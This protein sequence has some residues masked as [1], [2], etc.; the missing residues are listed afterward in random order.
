M[1]SWRGD[2][3][4]LCI[5]SF[6]KENQPWKLHLY[7]HLH[8]C[9]F[10]FLKIQPLR[11]KSSTFLQCLALSA[12]LQSPIAYWISFKLTNKTIFNLNWELFDIGH[13]L[14]QLGQLKIFDIIEDVCKVARHR[15]LCTVLHSMPFA[16]QTKEIQ[17]CF[18]P[19]RNFEV[20]P[21]T[22][23]IGYYLSSDIRRLLT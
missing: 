23:T 7:H 17:K 19:K 20:H 6:K 10:S 2:P 13:I 18:V 8:S 12:G 9:N 11:P 21:I 1:G 22:N 3:S 16:R 15:E 4:K 5:E 14:K